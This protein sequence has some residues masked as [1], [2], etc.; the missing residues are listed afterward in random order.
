MS[1]PNDNNYS[2]NSGNNGQRPPIPNSAYNHDD[3]NDIS[4][5]PS[6][7]DPS[8]LQSAP[9]N[10]SSYSQQQENNPYS[11][12]DNRSYGDNNPYNP[13]D[14]NPYGTPVTGSQPPL[15]HPE[16]NSLSVTSPF[17]DQASSLSLHPEPSNPFSSTHKISGSYNDEEYNSDFYEEDSVPLTNYP[18]QAGNNTNNRYN[19]INKNNNN[20]S[21]QNVTYQGGNSAPY[22]SDDAQLQRPQRHGT[23]LF[24]RITGSQPY[25]Q[26]PS[27]YDNTDS[28][29]SV[30]DVHI[31]YIQGLPNLPNIPSFSH[32]ENIY[33]PSILGDSYP[34]L[35][36]PEPRP[37]SVNTDMIDASWEY[38]QQQTVGENY[39]KRQVNLVNGVFRAE[40]PVPSLVKASVEPKY[41]DLEGA[42]TEFTHMRYTAATVDPDN[43]DEDHGYVLRAKEYNR[44]TELM[45]AVTYYSEDKVLTARTLYGVMKNVHHFCSDK[46]SSF[47]NNGS[48]PWQRIVVSIIMDGIE[49]CR[50]DTLDTLAAMGIY[51]DGVMKKAINDDKT[52]A[53]I[54]EYTSQI[55]ITPD[56]KLLRPN[57]EG[58]DY[59]VPPIQYILCLK[60]ENSKKINSHRWLFNAFSRQLNP[61]I[62]VLIDAGTKPAS[63]SIVH[64]WR[65]FYNNE[66]V[67]GA[68]GEI[69]AMLGKNLKLVA[70]N[71]MVA[72]QNF[73]YKI[74]NIL[75]KPLES[76]FG[77]ISV[78]PGA[79]SAYRYDAL[80]GRPLQ[81]YFK[82][83]HSLADRLGA[84]GLNGMNIF[85]RNMFLA[86]DRILCFE[87]TFKENKK[88]HLQYVKASRAETDVPEEID[89]FI[90]QRRRW[91]N[92]SF[93]AT[94]YSMMHFAQIYR[95]S[96]NPFRNIM[97]H[98][99]L[100]YNFV[101]I[102]LTWF[103]LAA[104]YLTTTV[105]MQLAADPN[106]NDILKDSAAYVTPF[107]SSNKT[108]SV[109][110]ALI[111]KFIY[112]VF[113]M[114][115]F[116]LALG[117]RPK[118]SRIQ[119]KILFVVF[120][121]I[122][123][124]AFVISIYL[125]VRAFAY[126]NGKPFTDGTHSGVSG[127]VRSAGFLVLLALGSTFGLYIISGII[128][129][130]V[131]HLIHSL[132]QY[133][134]IM[135][136]FTNV[137]NVYAFC[138]WHDVSWGTKGADKPD[139]LPAATSKKSK[140]DGAEVVEEIDRP[141]EDVD[142]MFGLVVERALKPYP[143]ETKSAPKI[144]IDD[145]NKA[146]RTN[147]IIF[148]MVCN[149]ILAV[150]LTSQSASEIGFATTTNRTKYY[151]YALIIITAIMA[152]LRLIGCTIFVTKSYLA[153]GFGKR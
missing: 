1:H 117:N 125:A 27:P 51:Q 20:I 46:K 128:Y 47:W 112:L 34:A 140:E 118:G 35:Q 41:I 149:A 49:P 97:L 98:V 115:S 8:P 116:I 139:A 18:P 124:Y 45:I 71:P 67:G 79:F 7:F 141:Q 136:S 36:M 153:R 123:C 11:A 107:P 84:E 38:R 17:Q 134:F 3:S 14:S 82:G 80:L 23:N 146:F 43:F 91:L 28:S 60:Q 131:G 113:L 72:A 100:F 86:E 63:K 92:G 111:L 150:G 144:D 96:H 32:N 135:P 61:N 52:V 6:R 126:S 89:E 76:T 65:A 22:P 120:G 24:N 75:D 10:P 33:F 77:F 109:S 143:K 108:V 142:K 151:F 83:D 56:L 13:P 130:D 5:H 59:N 2:N 103:S 145:E 68:C 54:F 138:N 129:L 95:T 42:S 99:Q 101:N 25:N 110:I 62:C 85:Q 64:L 19:D 102:I 137:V 132:P 30:S 152:L 93:A 58:S 4:N 70:T 26:A 105:I 37:N 114:I 29:E 74:S 9:Y 90:S 73:E 57:T 48:P 104:F 122:Q 147:L 15:H 21:Y 66:N 12:T 55:S 88:W 50:K 87:I 94:L 40:Y 44:E 69:H 121:L 53:H 148:W 119:Y 31:D 16:P 127:F 133:M 39:T 106:D 78:L 81:Q